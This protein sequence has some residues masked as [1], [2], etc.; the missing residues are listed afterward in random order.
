MKKFYLMILGFATA[1]SLQA[2]LFFQPTNLETPG[3]YK[4]CVVDINGDYFDDIVGVSNIGLHINKQNPTGG[5]T[6]QAIPVPNISHMPS[7]SMA[8]GDLTANGFNDLL[9]GGGQ[10]VSFLL[11]NNTGTAYTHITTNNYVFSQRSNFVDINNDGHLDA[12]VCHDVAP[13]VYYM[14]DGEGN[15]TFHQGGLGDFPSGGN[16]GSLWVDYNNDGHLDLHITKCGGGLDRSRDNLFR[17]NGDGTFTEVAEEAGLG[18]STQG[19]SS[20]WGDF[21]ND[22]FMDV[23]VGVNSFANGWHKMFRNNGDG[24]FTDITSSTIFESIGGTSIEH[25]TFDFDNN[26]YLD[27][28]GN[29]NRIFLNMGDFNFVEVSTPFSTGSVGDLNQDGFLDVYA[30]NNLYINQGNNNNWIIFNMEGVTSNR[31]G[32][33]A[34][35]EVTT[36]H[37]TMIREVRSGEGFR[38]MHTLNPHFGLGSDDII[39]SVRVKWPSGVVDTYTNVGINQIMMLTENASNM[40]VEEVDRLRGIALYPNPATD[41]FK[42]QIA[43]G[44]SAG[45]LEIMDA[46]GKLLHTT[47]A[48]DQDVK[49]SHLAPGLYFVKITIDG[50]TVNRK[51]IKK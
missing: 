50:N 4:I 22:G 43:E 39:E 9:L 24:T 33:G 2:Q 8:A 40:A 21:D 10:G 25:F 6:Y 42:V 35:I 14:N 45:S 5:F 30:G 11:A 27:I 28:A 41:H 31:N 49:I 3:N 47:T 23:F 26:G 12:F 44:F 19:W 20:A 38:H 1:G 37:R 36:N 34:R 51:I 15:L 13:N 17:N 7:W 18:I 32:I 48:I 46:S 16:Y 29:G